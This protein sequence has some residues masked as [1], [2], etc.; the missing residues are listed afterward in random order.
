M[1]I[2]IKSYSSQ[3]SLISS[4]LFFIL[5]AILFT[6]ADKV[7]K[8]FS[9]GI[10]IILAVS[11]VVSIVLFLF[12][13]RKN[14]LN[15]KIGN[16][17]FGAI[18][19]A[20]SIIFI[21]FSGLVEQFIR[22]IIGAWILFTGVIRLV[23][24]LSMNAKSTKFWQLLIVSLLLIIVGVWTIVVGDVFLTTYGLIMMIYAAI[25]IVG[26]ILYS[27][28]KVTTEEPEPGTTTLLVPEEIKLEET[29]KK[30]N[31]V[32]KTVKEKNKLFKKKNKEEK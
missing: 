1:E 30:D 21:F 22:F 23:N 19:L 28:G 18:A 11:A 4:I 10:G 20:L 2:K 17:A 12:Q 3:S 29:E 9:I 26:F 24:V 6:S 15:A 7:I 32:V 16:L 31:K 14:S 8:T 5:G 25:E 13:R 27:K